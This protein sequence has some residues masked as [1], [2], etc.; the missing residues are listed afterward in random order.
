MSQFLLPSDTHI[1]HTHLQVADLERSLHFYRDLVGFR[2]VR[3]D[4][5]TA[6]LSATGQLPA[7]IILTERPGAT[8]RPRRSTGLFHLAEPRWH[9]RNRLR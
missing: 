1:G 7:H 2:E 4:N 3:R 5:G 8:P 9:A 6:V